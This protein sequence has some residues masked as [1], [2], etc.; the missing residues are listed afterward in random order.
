[1]FYPFGLEGSKKL[2]KYFIDKKIPREKR[3]EIPLL[4]DGENIVAIIGYEVSDKYKADKNT[5]NILN[6]H[7][8]IER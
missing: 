4:V 8:N 1:M 5:K 6:I 7:Y 3:D 2:K